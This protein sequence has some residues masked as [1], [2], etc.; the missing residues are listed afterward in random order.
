MQPPGNHVTTTSAVP[1]ATEPPELL[2]RN[3]PLLGATALFNDTASEMAFWVLPFFLT[4]LGAGPAVLGLMEGLAESAISLLR[5]L[6]GYLTDHMRRRK[7]LVVAGYLVANLAKPLLAVARSWP[8]V[9]A[10]R[11]VD[12]SGKGFRG[13]PRDVMITE[14]ADPS[15]LGAAFG[16]R[17]AMDS[18]GAV[19]GPALAFLIMWH[20]RQNVRAVFWIAAVPGAIAVVIAAFFL[21]ET[22]TIHRS[23]SLAASDRGRT[24]HSRAS[25]GSS[26]YVLLAATALFGLANSTDMFLILRAQNLGL[27]PKF[28]P[29][30]GLVFNVVYA[31]LAYPFG[32]LS[33]RT[34]RKLVIG[35]GYLVF[36]AVYAGFAIV[37]RTVWIWPLFVCYGLYYALSEGVLRA[38]TADVVAAPARGRAFGWISFTTGGGALLASIVAGL[39]W[40]R[41]GASAPFVFSAVL[42]AVAAVLIL[43]LRPSSPELRYNEN[44]S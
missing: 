27:N 10:L 2:K 30:L 1:P 41:F 11:V 14:S 32:S 21:R 18:A 3:V 44:S 22:G 25:F 17:Q 34:S 7:P 36:A 12:R 43:S 39:L 24:R 19:L 9:L 33:D 4:R 40:K 29:L 26:F 28:A 37:H 8:Q 20:T 42:A 31:G 23:V 13:A 35:S 6:S 16:L 38:L 15:R 5:L